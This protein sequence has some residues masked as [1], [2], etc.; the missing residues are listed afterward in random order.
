[1]DLPFGA[2]WTRCSVKSGIG[3]RWNADFPVK[4]F[5]NK[6]Q[7]VNNRAIAVSIYLFVSELIETVREKEISIFV[8][9]FVKFLK[10]L[11]WQIPKGVEMDNAYYDLLK[12][13]TNV[14]HAAGE[15]TSIEKRHDFLRDYFD[16]YKDKGLIRGDN[17]YSQAKKKNPNTERDKIELK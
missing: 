2:Y 4:Y 13:Q 1:V 5:G 16:Y 3:V 17:E 12:F 8:E 14:A 15:K 11:K 7:Y 10:T 6:L 9:F